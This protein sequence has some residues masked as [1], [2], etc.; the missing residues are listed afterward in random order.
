MALELLL[1]GVGM[2][3]LHGVSRMTVKPAEAWRD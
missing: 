3:D 2:A 1:I